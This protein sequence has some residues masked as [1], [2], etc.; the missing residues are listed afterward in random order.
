MSDPQQPATSEGQH[1]TDPSTDQASQSLTQSGDQASTHTLGT[2][3]TH[4]TTHARDVT[5]QRQ[6]TDDA[7]PK[8]TNTPADHDTHT[9]VQPTASSTV[10]APP[11]DAITTAA[12]REA[13]RRTQDDDGLLFESDSDEEQVLTVVCKKGVYYHKSADGTLTPFK[14]NQS[15]TISETSDST[16][17]SAE[18]AALKQKA[19]TD[20]Q[21]H[22]KARAYLNSLPADEAV[23]VEHLRTKLHAQSFAGQSNSATASASTKSSPLVDDIT[24]QMR[25]QYATMWKTIG[26]KL[27][28]ALDKGN[29][30]FVSATY[31]YRQANQAVGQAI[32]ANMTGAVLQAL[33]DAAVAAKQKRIAAKTQVENALTELQTI[34]NNLRMHDIHVPDTIMWRI[35]ESAKLIPTD[36]SSK[37]P[38]FDLTEHDDLPS[39]HEES[40]AASTIKNVSAMASEDVAN[41]DLLKGMYPDAKQALPKHLNP[42]D[43]ATAMLKINEASNIVLDP[44]NQSWS[45]YQRNKRRLEQMMDAY[46]SIDRRR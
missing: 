29:S 32:A 6:H 2:N 12:Q 11:T 17:S 46:M 24:R 27:L 7:V 14:G 22:A 39:N 3:N 5:V 45:E 18:H 42:V 1:T 34:T 4:S 9:N 43:A 28:E 25:N 10:I 8:N 20:E 40:H 15:S 33:T 38:S 31:E 23:D 36:I 41:S 37:V 16:H 35:H 44:K 30:D 21:V 19:V 26:N 13:Q